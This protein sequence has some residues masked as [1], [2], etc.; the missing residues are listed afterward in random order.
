MWPFKPPT[1]RKAGHA[2]YR[3]TGPAT[4]YFTGTGWSRDAQKAYR[5]K[6]QGA[7][8]DWLRKTVELT[9]MWR[10]GVTKIKGD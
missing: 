3:H 6:S 4:M 9:K 5:F 8:M 1:G 10:Y 2:I 7:A